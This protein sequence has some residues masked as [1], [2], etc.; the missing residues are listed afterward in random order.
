MRG[1][2]FGIEIGRTGLTTAQFGLD[3]TGHNISNM[4][5]EGYTRQR[6]V[7]TAHDPFATIG[8]FAPTPGSMLVGGGVRV[9]ISD[10]CRHIDRPSQ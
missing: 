4:D 5:T 7:S 1:T 10:S 8:R 3:V 6:I 2:F 9:Q